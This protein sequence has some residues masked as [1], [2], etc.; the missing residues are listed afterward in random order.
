MCLTSSNISKVAMNLAVTI[1][2]RLLQQTSLEEIEDT[3]D[4]VLKES[5]KKAILALA[6]IKEQWDTGDAGNVFIR[7]MEQSYKSLPNTLALTSYPRTHRPYSQDNRLSL[8]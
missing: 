2:Y 3:L 4:S 5:L 1:V 7:M 8:C 6:A